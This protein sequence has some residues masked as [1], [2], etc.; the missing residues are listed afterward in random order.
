MLPVEKSVNNQSVI[1]D[2]NLES[3]ISTARPRFDPLRSFDLVK[4]QT[5]AYLV[6]VAQAF[7]KRPILPSR[8]DS[9]RRNP[10]LDVAL[11]CA[12][13]DARLSRCCGATVLSEAGRVRIL[14][15]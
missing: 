11:E 15:E 3:G 12:D 9:L 5:P 4:T 7:V 10:S 1:V 14:R 13:K 6:I 8:S 2:G